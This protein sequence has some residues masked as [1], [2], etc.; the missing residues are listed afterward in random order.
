MSLPTSFAH[1]RWALATLI[2]ATLIGV[3]TASAVTSDARHVG[4]ST[5][6]GRA[7]SGP[8]RGLGSPPAS[9]AVR[10]RAVGCV[11]RGHAIAYRGGPRRK[12]VALTFDDGPWPDTAAF[13]RM[14]EAQRVPATFFMIGEQVTAQYRWLLHRELRDGDALGD[15]TYTHPDLVMSGGVY[16]QLHRTMLAIGG[17]T[18]YTPC[19]FRPPGGNYDRSVVDTA[20]SLGLA[21]VLWNVDPADWTLP[22]TNTIVQRVLAQVQPGSIVISHDGGGPRGQ[23]LAAYPRIIRALRERGYRFETVPQLLGFRTVYRRCVRTCQ[24]EGVSRP[25]AQ[26]SSAARLHRPAEPFASRLGALPSL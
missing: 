23:T 18:G 20:R 6:Q 25:P 21:T 11:D 15:H 24:G 9:P 14:L 16:D 19:V 22:G 26:G 12:V 7:P 4:I 8:A 5:Y 10:Y 13:V 17:L 1:R 3:E 2:A